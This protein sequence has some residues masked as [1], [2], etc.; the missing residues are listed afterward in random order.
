VSH[1]SARPDVIVT[2]KPK[3][4]EKTST[5]RFPPYHVILENDD[6]HTFDFVVDVLRK[7]LG[8]PLER[9]LQ[10]TLQAHTSGRA[11]I[12]TGPKEVAELKVEQVQTFHQIHPETGAKLGPLGC[13][14]EPAP[15]G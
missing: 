4:R 5:R 10:L 13:T 11:I 12:W 7:V 1:D 2:T 3:E 14:L 6:Y 15:G 8:C 9:A